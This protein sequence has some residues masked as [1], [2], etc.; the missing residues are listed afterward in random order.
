MF[1]AWWAFR[2]SLPLPRLPKPLGSRPVTPLF[3]DLLQMI[4]VC[5]PSREF[6]S[7]LAMAVGELRF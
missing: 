4:S 1:T 6:S 2:E 5:Q 3:F 7:I